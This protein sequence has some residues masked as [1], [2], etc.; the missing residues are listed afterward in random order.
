MKR[1][2]TLSTWGRNFSLVIVFLLTAVLCTLPFSAVRG[3][4]KEVKILTL[5]EALRIT[6]EKN[7][8]IQKASEYRNLVE[9][10]YVE[11]RAAALPQFVIAAHASNSRDESQKAFGIGLPLR[12]NTR[13][14]ELGLSQA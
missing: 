11:E 4:E 14:V 1:T 10:R 12:S 6:A 3:E 2:I 8:D 9:S 5:E 7:R 13:S